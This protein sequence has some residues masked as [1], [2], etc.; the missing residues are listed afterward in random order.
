MKTK[1]IIHGKDKGKISGLVSKYGFEIVEKNPDFIISFGGDGTVMLSESVYPGIPKIIL[2][3]S[4]VCKLCSSLENEEVL[5]R[6]KSGKYKIDA[7]INEG[8]KIRMHIKK[9]YKNQYIQ[10]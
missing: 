1:V 3:N 4:H 5:E 9:W 10:F 2:R 8:I 7:T 6:V